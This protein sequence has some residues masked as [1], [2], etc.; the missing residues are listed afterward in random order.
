[1]HFSFFFEGANRRLA[2]AHDEVLA[3]RLWEDEYMVPGRFTASMMDFSPT[4]AD[5]AARPISGANVAKS[6]ANMVDTLKVPTYMIML[7]RMSL[8]SDAEG[9][10]DLAKAKKNND[11]R[12]ASGAHTSIAGRELLRELNSGQSDS[13]LLYHNLK[14][15]DFRVL[16]VDD[17]VICLCALLMW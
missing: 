17:E 1:V 11:L 6:K 16:F 5:W 12:P 7:A 13:P 2:L 9:Q 4:Q 14:N 3:L 8:S 15:V 10:F